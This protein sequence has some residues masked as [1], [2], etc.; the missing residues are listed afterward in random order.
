[1]KIGKKLFF[2]A[3]VVVFFSASWAGAATII[4]SPGGLQTA[5]DNANPGD[6]LLLDAGTFSEQ[7]TIDGKNKLTIKGQGTVTTTIDGSAISGPLVTISNS[8]NITLHSLSINDS[9]DDINLDISQC[10]DIK[11]LYLSL[12]GASSHCV[13]VNDTVGT[14]VSN[15]EFAHSQN[16]H[17]FLLEDHNYKYT[18]I[19]NAF[20][21]NDVD[22]LHIGPSSAGLVKFNDFT[23]NGN[24]GL[25]IYA[26][27]VKVLTN[28][29]A[30]NDN[31][32]GFDVS[33][34]SNGDVFFK[35]NTSFSNYYGYYFAEGVLAMQNYAIENLYEG[36]DDGYGSVYKKNYSFDNGGDGFL[37]D[38]GSI[39]FGNVAE[40]NDGSYGILLG[41]GNGYAKGNK[42]LDNTGDGLYT[43][44]SDVYMLMGNFAD[45]NTVNG[46]RA[47][48]S[49]VLAT[50]NRLS[51]NTNSGFYDSDGYGNTVSKNLSMNNGGSG[52]EMYYMSLCVKNRSMSNGVDGIHFNSN[53][54]Y[55]TKNIVTNNTANGINPNGYKGSLIEAN[56][57]KY[58]GDGAITFDLY[59]PTATAVNF[60]EGN[61]YLTSNFTP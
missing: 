8:S 33:G 50:K 47:N 52:I 6:V 23:N 19:N 43:S 12:N 45:N 22:G 41:G 37:G 55:V 56:I 13:A 3:S 40:R 48:S 21:F 44:S 46:I 25:Y 11:L 28:Y 31:S 20:E 27:Q 32:Y 15:S 18:F 53:V 14:F 51:N 29:A 5:I 10:K 35:G 36:F 1:M 9:L 2:A 60:W 30:D 42:V 7:V 49:S 57:A 61:K 54:N 39:F 58:N 16:G 59:E 4:V 17:G 38:D 24:D 34:Y 26:G